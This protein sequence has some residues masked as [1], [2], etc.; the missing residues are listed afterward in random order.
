M[1]YSLAIATI[2]LLIIALG[3]FICQILFS[4]NLAQDG[5]TLK[6]LTT[7]VEG[8]SSENERLEQQI[9]S[10]SS[11]MDIHEKAVDMGFVEA[12]HFLTIVQGQYLVSLTQKK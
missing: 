1:K 5:S 4:N 2:L 12:K 9:A 8:L 7:K 11:L 3:L 10:A 6:D